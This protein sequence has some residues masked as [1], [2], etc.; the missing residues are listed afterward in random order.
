MNSKKIVFGLE[1][2]QALLRGID[3][4]ANA[5]KVT[6]GPKGRNV[7]YQRNHGTPAITKDG[8]TVAKQIILKDH[9]ENMG[10]EL[11]HE[12][13]SKTAMVA[14]DG[15]TTATVLA[16]SLFREGNKYI[17][18]GV[19]PTALKRGI[20]KAVEAV[21]A[22]LRADAVK[23]TDQ[24]SIENIAVISA[25]GD[26]SIGKIIAH[27][28][29]KVGLDGI[30][31]VEEA[32]G[33]ED[34][35]EL[36]EGLQFDK[37]YMS[38]YFVTNEE[39]S[40]C[41]LEEPFI[42]LYDKKISSIQSIIKILE[43]CIKANRSL[44]IIAEDIDHEVL[45][46]L[47]LNKMRGS[48]KIA[49]V[50]LPGFGDRKLAICEDIATLIGGDFVSEDRGQQ[51]DHLAMN[52]L[53]SARRVILAKHSTTI[54]DGRGDLIKLEERIVSL[55]NQ[56]EA[57]PSEY[58]KTRIKERLANLA[59]GVAVIKLSAATETEMKEKRDRVDDALNATKAA[60]EEGIVA[61]GG[62]ALLRQIK[63]VD[64]LISSINNE[65]E[66]AGAKLVKRV[67]TEPIRI[68]CEN[69]DY[70]AAV[71]INKL[72]NEKDEIGFDAL[73]GEMC[74]LIERG[75]IDPVKVTVHALQNAVSVSALLLTTEAAIY[76]DEEEDAPIGPKNYP[77]GP[78]QRI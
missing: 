34:E 42:L 37:G 75:I 44:L 6:L 1:G 27:A 49:A 23:I 54:I 24:E 35:L 29:E 64:A 63:S 8:V 56:Y 48:L 14:G 31:T 9:L 25:N 47:V 16:Q 59:G 33:I 69:A 41:V 36:V 78:M 5:V 71:I 2:R 12:V 52:S 67:I 57:A 38:P 43:H 15:T 45:T 39:K 70:D 51:L 11:V 53:G 40:E 60:I 46:T 32:K 28:M 68:I 7:I 55:R 61:G 72:M 20:D 77:M 21:I 19:N 76:S 58:E 22:G 18:A 3:T 26:V 62:L 17:T 4:L 73:K 50:K 66:L 65:D 74:N 13:A 30:V 10:A